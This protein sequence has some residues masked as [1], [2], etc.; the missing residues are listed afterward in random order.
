[1][2]AHLNRASKRLLEPYGP[3]AVLALVLVT[4]AGCK[5]NGAPAPIHASGHIEAT[6]VRLAAKVGGKLAELPFQEGDRVKTGAVV[7]RLETTDAERELVRARAE[8][9]GA[10]ARLRLLLA[11]TRKEDVARAEADLARVEADLAGARLDLGRLEGLADRGSGTLKARD[12]A[13]TRVAVLTQQ[14]EAG[15]AELAKLKAGARPEEIDQARAQKA[16]AEA[17]VA[18]IE[19]KITDATVVAPR[20]GVITSRA[21]EPGEVLPVG[22]LLEVLTDL[23]HPWLTVYVDQPSLSSIALGEP[24]TVR[25][26]GQSKAFQGKVS[27]VSDVAEFTPKNVQTPEERAKLVFKVKI[28]LDNPD[29]V[30]KPGMPADAYFG[31][32]RG[33]VKQGSGPGGRGA[34]RPSDPTRASLLRCPD[35]RPASQAHREA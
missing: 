29:G 27:F 26:D 32:G 30:F 10:D 7:A 33:A 17:S 13:R 8:A 14:R 23:E 31:A 6:E 3:L 15:A 25:V 16:A 22:A 34:G 4:V 24:V 5:G 18:V 11:G 20:D 21:T 19:Q 12:D 9:A 2:K 28:M 1:V 35:R